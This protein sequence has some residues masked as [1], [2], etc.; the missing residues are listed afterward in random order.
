MRTHDNFDTFIGVTF[1]ANNPIMYG[2]RKAA[3]SRERLRLLG[4]IGEDGE[5]QCVA[6]LQSHDADDIFL[7]PMLNADTTSSH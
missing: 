4:D 3:A 7:S 2:K 5:T 6:R 1:N